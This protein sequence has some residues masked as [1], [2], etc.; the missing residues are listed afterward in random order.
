MGERIREICY[1]DM[2]R[3]LELLQLGYSEGPAAVDTVD[4][5]LQSAR[6]YGRFFYLWKCMSF[7]HL[8][9][10]IIPQILV[11]EKE[12][13]VVGVRSVRRRG[14]HRGPFLVIHISVDPAFRRQ[15]I[16]RRMRSYFEQNLDPDTSHS[17]LHKVLETNTP[18]MNSSEGGGYHLYARETTFFLSPD[19]WSQTVRVLG[20]KVDASVSLESIISCKPKWREIKNLK[21]R[22]I[23]SEMKRCDPQSVFPFGRPPGISNILTNIFLTRPE[24][25][26]GIIINGELVG[27]AVLLYHRLQRTYELDI[28]ALPEHND[29]VY[30]LLLQ[31]MNHLSE[32]AKAP[33]N[34]IVCDYQTSVVEVL[35]NSDFAVK[36]KKRLY[37]KKIDP[38]LS[39]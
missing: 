35:K 2:K 39:N 7:L 9:P 37:Y 12:G 23:P 31:V 5:L 4:A 14:G 24:W 36:E 33:V 1:R 13:V 11:F 10:T 19:V 6:L 28:S 16:A 32:R 3:Y 22:E 29:A 30:V 8:F 38:R 27:S 15:N 34:V 21:V 25:K 17:I 20:K 18:Q 26:G